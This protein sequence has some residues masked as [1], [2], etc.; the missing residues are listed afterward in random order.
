MALKITPS[1]RHALQLLANGYTTNNVA[2]SLGI[3]A[4]ETEV[5]LM[6]LFAALGAASQAEIRDLH[7]VTPVIR[8][9]V[10]TTPVAR[11]LLDLGAVVPAPLLH[12]AVDDARR[13][14][15]TDWD[16]L[17]DVLV[18]HARRGRRGVGPAGAAAG[19]RRRGQGDRQRVRAAGRL[20]PRLGRPAGSGRATPGRTGRSPIPHR[21]RVPRAPP[22]HRARRWAPPAP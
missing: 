6:R 9:G 13:R 2:T 17:L 22:G 4:V 12:L 5:L 16:A 11:T 7:L 19:P 14:G 18:A 21:P 15:L 3:G 20:L 1:E 10:P 8:N